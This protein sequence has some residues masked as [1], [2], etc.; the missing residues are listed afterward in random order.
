MALRWGRKKRDELGSEKLHERGLLGLPM[1]SLHA[2]S[3]S[4]VNVLG[5]RE[6]P[7]QL[8]PSVCTLAAVATVEAETD[9]FRRSRVATLTPSRVAF[10]HGLH[11]SS[12]SRTA[13]LSGHR[14][15]HRRDFA[16]LCSGVFVVVVFCLF[17]AKTD[18]VEM[19]GADQFRVKEII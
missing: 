8:S 5:V 19:T 1:Q 6:G 14:Q 11:A 13:T 17:K 15:P 9:R 4:G 12:P 16:L 2:S 3:E 7:W 18:R 10:M